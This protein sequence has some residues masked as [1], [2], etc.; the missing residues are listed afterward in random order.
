MKEEKIEGNL[1]VERWEG[2]LGN[3][4]VSGLE[5]NSPD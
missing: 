5:D 2:F 3:T 4:S 1:K